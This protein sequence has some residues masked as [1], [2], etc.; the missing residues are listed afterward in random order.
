MTVLPV[1]S[2]VT[3]PEVSPD[4]G[5]PPRP[6]GRWS[7]GRHVASPPPAE[8]VVA[9]QGATAYP[10]VSL[11]LPTTPAP[12]M[13]E[14]D[15]ARLQGLLATAERRLESEAHP[16]RQSVGAAL[17]E[18]V[19]EAC[20]R[21]AAAGLAVFASPSGIRVTVRLPIAV[22]ERV[23]VDPTFATRD[24]V[25]A[26]HRTPRH[27]VLLL[28]G[29]EARL[30]TG[31]GAELQPVQGRFPMRPRRERRRDPDRPRLAAADAAA[32]WRDVD[33]ALGAYLLAHPAPL[34]IAGDRRATAGFVALSSHLDRLA[35]TLE[36][37][38]ARE[39]LPRLAERV[40]PVLEGYLRSRQD[41]ALALLDRRT[42]S[43]RAVSGLV[44]AWFAARHERPEMLVV[45]ESLSVP[46]RLTSD[47]DLV[48]PAVD[49]EA[50]DV[51]DDI[52]DELIETVLRRGGWVALARPG[53][54][55]G[56]GGVALTLRSRP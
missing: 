16:E 8:L 24:L 17:A 48:V 51:L 45:D 28:T 43:G 41:E 13:T 33:A 7:G 38:L 23:V 15:R 50:P 53:S 52:V 18:L 56:H 2:G 29:Q 49:P 39:P 36:A 34:V 22:S 20:T 37:N 3:R 6:V 26:L 54:L 19:A 12:R 27:V 35:G 30:F 9:L 4:T 1:P 5:L 55:D 11:L 21:E 47:G 32:F 46:A 10:A 42:G 44:A 31:L 25:H 40:R 14:V